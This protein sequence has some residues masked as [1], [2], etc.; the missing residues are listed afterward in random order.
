MGWLSFLILLS[1]IKVGL[2]ISQYLPQAILNYKR[3]STCGWNI[4]NNF[5]GTSSFIYIQTHLIML[6][7]ISWVEYYHYF[8]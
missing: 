2:S 5:L 4:W 6:I 3:K 8:N 7:K 1:S